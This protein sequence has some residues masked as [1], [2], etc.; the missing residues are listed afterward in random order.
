MIKKVSKFSSSTQT[1]PNQEINVPVSSITEKQSFPFT[2]IDETPELQDPYSDLSLFLAQQIKQELDA[3]K[4]TKK[5][6]FYLQEKLIKKIAPEFQKK[7][8]K[9]RLGAAALKRIGEKI[10]Y[11]SQF[12]EDKTDALTLDGKL[13]EDFLIR[14]NLKE[15]LNYQKKW[16][17]HP[18]LLAQQLALKISECLATYNGIRPV[19]HHITKTIW[20]IQKHLISPSKLVSYPIQD[21]LDVWD[22]LILKLLI[23]TISS[24]SVSSQEWLQ[25]RIRNELI[26]L[27]S[28]EDFNSTESMLCSISIILAKTLY[29]PLLLTKELEIEYLLKLKCCIKE[30]I[31]T[32]SSQHNLI[33]LYLHLKAHYFHSK[34]NKEDFSLKDD[35]LNIIYWKC[36][37][38]LQI[39][40]PLAPQT[41]EK[42]MEEL[43]NILVDNPKE[44]FISAVQ[45]TF[46]FFSKAKQLILSSNL[47]EVEQRLT[48]WTI[49]GD[50]IFRYLQIEEHPLLAFFVSFSDLPLLEIQTAYLKRYPYL[51]PFIQQLKSHLTIFEKLYWYQSPNLKQFSSIECFILRYLKEHTT[52]SIEQCL[53]N[54]ERLFKSQFPLFPFLKGYILE[55]ISKQKKQT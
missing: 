48:L 19:L 16:S 9:Y 12:L 8:P 20:V 6:S 34:L 3:E 52:Q 11:F 35:E 50:L 31:H 7:F 49:Q 29:E 46:N 23:G 21:E 51:S 18:Y 39:L 44:S 13:K 33:E 55:F 25:N 32:L 47:I 1:Q 38:E 43:G 10:L 53:L 26:T 22:K 17:F 40:P 45:R 36:V 2:F 42:I 37:E 41:C 54:L 14:E 30:Q 24:S 15:V 4:P 28:W 27:R 5:W